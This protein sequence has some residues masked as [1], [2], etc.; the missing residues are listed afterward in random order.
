MLVSLD[1][2][3]EGVLVW[4][5]SSI[6]RHKP[7]PIADYWI[8]VL[9]KPTQPDQT[10]DIADFG[11]RWL[12]ANGPQINH[13]EDINHYDARGMFWAKV[14][15]SQTVAQIMYFSIREAIWK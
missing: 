2:V 13:T 7:E 14:Q 1:P 4:L 9:A 8:N 11:E 15:G 6:H 12:I 5:G 10:D 3:G